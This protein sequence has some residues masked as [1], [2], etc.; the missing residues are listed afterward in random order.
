MGSLKVDAFIGNM[1]V[2]AYANTFDLSN[3]AQ[4]LFDETP[5]RTTPSYAALGKTKKRERT[6]RVGVAGGGWWWSGVTRDRWWIRWQK[7]EGGRDSGLGKK[8]RRL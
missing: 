7:M 6:M 2:V 3:H 1:L 8:K 5:K 4:I